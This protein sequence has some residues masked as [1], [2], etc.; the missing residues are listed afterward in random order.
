MSRL[1]SIVETD[2]IRVFCVGKDIS[3]CF[4]ISDQVLLQDF[5]FV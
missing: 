4:G 2:D 5:V 1:E 3:L